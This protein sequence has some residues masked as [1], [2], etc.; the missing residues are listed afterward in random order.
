[1][2]YWFCHTSTCIRHGCTCVPHPEPPTHRPPHTIPLGHPSAPAPGVQASK[3]CFHIFSFT[4]GI[5]NSYYFYKSVQK[6]VKILAFDI[7]KET[8]S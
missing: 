8:K 3:N 4:T 1:M 5:S 6:T 7:N 2:L